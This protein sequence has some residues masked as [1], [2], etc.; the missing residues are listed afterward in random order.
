MIETL[1]AYQVTFFIFNG[2]STL[3]PVQEYTVYQYTVC[4]SEKKKRSTCFFY[5]YIS[6]SKLFVF[7]DHLQFSLIHLFPIY[8]GRKESMN[9][10]HFPHILAGV[11]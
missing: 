10:I 11:L 6:Y 8:R 9:L 5:N 2:K 1:T 3:F 7:K 4:L